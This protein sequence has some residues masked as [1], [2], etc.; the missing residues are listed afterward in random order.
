MNPG[1]DIRRNVYKGQH[2]YVA[3]GIFTISVE[4]PNR[5]YGI[6]NI[7]NSVNIPFFIQSEL[8]INP[9]GL[10]ILLNCSTLLWI[11]AVSIN[12][13]FITPVRTTWMVTAFL[14]S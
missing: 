1:N 13:M 7:P 11:M 3:G 9:F 6:V 14:I 8:V 2:T 5:N 4:D 12:F 10:I